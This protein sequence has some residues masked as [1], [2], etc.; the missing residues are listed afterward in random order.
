[1]YFIREGYLGSCISE[2]KDILVLVF[3]KRRIFRFM[4]FRREGYSGSC[5]SEE[6]DI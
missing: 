4:Y 2:E 3:H 1:L 5:I 6:K